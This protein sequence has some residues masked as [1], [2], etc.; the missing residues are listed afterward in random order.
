MHRRLSVVAALAIVGSLLCA[1]RTAGAQPYAITS[2]VVAGGGATSSTGG[3]FTLGGTIGQAD[4]SGALTGSPYVVT[5]GWWSTLVSSGSAFTDDPLTAGVTFVRTVHVTELRTR[6]DSL[7]VHFGLGAAVYTDPTLTAGATIV[8]GVH[9]QE[10]RQ[11]LVEAYQAAMTAPPSFT[12]PSLQSGTTQ[13]R[14][15]HITELR[16]AVEVLE[17]F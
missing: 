7:R 8:R 13:I 1:V 6:I 3:T 17:A 11:A 16:V 9:I 12:D 4:A 2:H 15:V 5:G 14:A 10:L